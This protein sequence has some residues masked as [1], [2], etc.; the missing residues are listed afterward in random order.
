MM[1]EPGPI[2]PTLQALL[3]PLGPLPFSED[4]AVTGI[5]ADS[6]EVQPGY[7]FVAHAGTEVDGHDFLRQAVA[8]GAVAVVAEREV[9][10]I[11]VPVLR[12]EDARRTLAEL[13]AAWYGRPA[14]A[15][16]LV[17]ITGSLGKTSILKMLEAILAEGGVR[18]GAI[19]SEIIGIRV[20]DELEVETSHTTP[21]PL[22]LHYGLRRLC[23]EDAEVACMEVSSHGLDQERVHGLSFALG[24]FSNLVA[25]EHQDYHGSFEEYTSAKGRFFNYLRRGAPLVYGADS[26]RLRTQ[27]TERQASLSER[28]IVLFGCGFDERAEVG[29][30]GVDSTAEGTTYRLEVRS[31]LRRHDGTVLEPASLHL[32]LRL[33]GRPHVINSAFAATAALYLGVEGA[34]IQRALAAIP[35]PERR[36]QA[37][38]FKGPRGAF[39]V[40]DDTA[41]HPNSIDAVF[42]VV[43]QLPH[44]GL[45]VVA[46]IRGQRGPEINRRLAATIARR[47]RTRPFDT[48]AV[49]DSA[50][51][52]GDLDTVTHGEREA[53]LEGLRECEI[54]VE[55]EQQLTDALSLVL[56]RVG[57]RDLV[58]LVGAQGMRE[59]AELLRTKLDA[60]SPGG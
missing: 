8:R 49:T 29:I 59:G 38:S 39:H 10:T 54:P 33:L 52:V 24:V 14:E 57:G 27:L 6:R 15:L 34:A 16:T 53:F 32:R 28:G 42:D 11:P 1:T 25:L 51:T 48:L 13:A 31:P 40:L 18:V 12:V 17:G 7:V 36:M 58:V 9:G 43:D 30:A 50:E 41:A 46:A 19:G 35:P 4:P 22:T 20:Q 45:H 5:T 60:S 21:G 56:R 55:H 23:D 3:A 44:Q 2:R 37:L 26:E 47:C